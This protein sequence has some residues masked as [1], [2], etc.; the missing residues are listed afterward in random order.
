MT[1]SLDELEVIKTD[2]VK[3]AI[4]VYKIGYPQLKNNFDNKKIIQKVLDE[5][6]SLG[7]LRNELEKQMI[8]Q[9]I[10]DENRIPIIN[11]AI[12]ADLDGKAL[13]KEYRNIHNDDDGDSLV[14]SDP[15]MMNESKYAPET[16]PELIEEDIEEENIEKLR[17]KY[18]C[19][20]CLHNHY[21]DSNIGKKHISNKAKSPRI[22][23]D[24]INNLIND[25][26]QK[27]KI[28]DEYIQ[29]VTNDLKK[30][31]INNEM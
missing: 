13:L 28:A 19:Q 3:K 31:V 11:A 1:K 27:V 14:L 10:T 8:N 24:V 7:L 29:F 6:R 23:K 18:Y 15:F 26:Y 5:Y 30:D 21:Y 25:A 12:F 4:A 20:E 9:M 16:E 2:L 22:N 17:E